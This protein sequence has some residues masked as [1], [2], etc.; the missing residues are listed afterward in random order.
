MN[1]VPI[2]KLTRNGQQ[3]SCD[4]IEREGHIPVAGVNDSAASEPNLSRLSPLLCSDA[5]ATSLGGVGVILADGLIL[6]VGAVF[7]EPLERDDAENEPLLGDAVA[8]VEVVVVGPF[9]GRLD[10]SS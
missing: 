6:D 8:E 10:A 9:S 2:Q 3:K 1:R 7:E 5:D 4:G